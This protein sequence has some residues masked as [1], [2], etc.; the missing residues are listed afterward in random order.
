VGE[1]ENGENLESIE[2][3]LHRLDMEI[4][5]VRERIIYMKRGVYNSP[6]PEE[7]LNRLESRYMELAESFSKLY[8]E[9]RAQAQAEEKAE[10]E[11]VID[12]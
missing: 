2:I 6:N 12:E 5:K 9:W 4:N 11:D 3:R 1:H 10:E 8:E 7:E